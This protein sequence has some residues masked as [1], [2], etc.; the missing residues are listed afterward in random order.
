MA[1]FELDDAKVGEAVLEKRVFVDDRFDFRAALADRQD[2][3]AIPRCFFLPET[4]KL[5]EAYKFLQELHVRRHVRVYS[6]K[7]GL[8]DKFDDEHR[9]LACIKHTAG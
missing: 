7:V 4:R 1:G 8:V 5:P 3:P 9:R 6:G 2:D